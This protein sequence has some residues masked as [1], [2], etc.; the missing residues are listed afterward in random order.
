MAGDVGRSDVPGDDT[1]HDEGTE[2]RGN[3]GVV[4]Y[5]ACFEFLRVES[6]R[7][8]DV[9]DRTTGVAQR[10]DEGSTR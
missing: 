1:A 7:P 2:H 8:E 9:A 3:I 5:G 10:D 6:E 4:D